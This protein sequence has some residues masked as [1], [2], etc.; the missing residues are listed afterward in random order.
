MDAL[1]KILESIGIAKEKAIEIA[2]DV[3]ARNPDNAGQAA[4]WIEARIREYA[5]PALDLTHLKETLLGIGKDIWSG[6]TTVDPD[7]WLGSV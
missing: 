4:E 6:S 1:L 7:A 5:D 3:A 2:K